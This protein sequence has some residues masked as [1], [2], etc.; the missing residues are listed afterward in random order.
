MST[1]DRSVYAYAWWRRSAGNRPGNWTPLTPG[2]MLT[3]QKQ[4]VMKHVPIR[5]GEVMRLSPMRSRYEYICVRML[6][7]EE[8]Y[9]GLEEV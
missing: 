9:D 5:V 3:A 2:Q 7:P 4:F 6:V 1:S 8:V